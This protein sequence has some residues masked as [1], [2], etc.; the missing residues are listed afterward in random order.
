MMRGMRTDA[1]QTASGHQDDAC[2]AG[3]V[4]IDVYWTVD[5]MHVLAP[6]RNDSSDSKAW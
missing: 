2:D 4:P 5:R 3:C 6:I 1:C